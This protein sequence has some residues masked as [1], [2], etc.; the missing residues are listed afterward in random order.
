M[1]NLLGKLL[2]SIVIS[3]CYFWIITKPQDMY[4]CGVPAKFELHARISTHDQI[5]EG[6]DRRFLEHN[7]ATFASK[8]KMSGEH[9][10]D[11]K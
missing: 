1:R 5:K 8:A 10:N 11:I 2:P 9:F 4:T 6:L 7:S 3:E